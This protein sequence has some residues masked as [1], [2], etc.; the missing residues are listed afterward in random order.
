MSGALLER[1][2]GLFLAPPA[3]RALAVPLAVDEAPTAVALLCSAEAAAP[4]ATA[5]G[6]AAAR[7]SR[8]RCALICRW[9]G[10]E[11]AAVVAGP[12]RPAARRLS[13][14]LSGRELVAMARGRVVTVTLPADPI[15][16][17][18]A[19]ERA[20]G[21][22]PDV[23][24]VLVLCGPRPPELDGVLAALD[25][26]IVCLDSAATDGLEEIALVDAS[27]VGRATG[28]LRAAQ[29]LDARLAVTSGWLLSAGLRRTA[30]AAL[31][32]RDG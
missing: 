26:V 21:A 15:E 31:D 20:A 6:L 18:V 3:A 5:L 4:A 24:L 14:R 19:C 17:K 22:A 11:K 30:E 28:V 25:R 13:R 9:S 7:R 32:G 10:T 29:G 12:A 27:R 23:P 1:V 8:A 16:A 2:V